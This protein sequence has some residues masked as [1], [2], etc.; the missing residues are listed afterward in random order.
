MLNKYSK[1]KK[2]QL[3]THYKK[4]RNALST[5]QVA[6]FSIQIANLTLQ[7]PIWDRSFFHVF[8]TI[9]SL[10]EVITDPILSILLGKDKHIVLSK[11]NFETRTLSH[12]LLQDNTRIKLNSWNI[13]EPENGIAITTDQIEVIF[14]P[15]LAFDVHGNRVGYG[16]GFYDEF[17]KD[18]SNGTI[19]IGLSFFEAEATIDGIESHD[20][21]LDYCITPQKVYTF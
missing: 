18:C 1:V 10:K 17:L 20:I 5:K 15:L 11:S 7:L 4:L 9:E 16:K 12:V 21:S 19:K 6:D 13:P 2:Q 3:R 14:I 8:L